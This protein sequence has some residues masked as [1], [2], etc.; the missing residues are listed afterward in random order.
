MNL[1][2][3]LILF[4]ILI[5]IYQ[6]F[7]QIFSILF[8]LTGLNMDRSK[9][10]VISMLT[11]TGFTTAESESV[12]ST[13]RRRRL[14][15]DLMLFSYIFNISI[16]STFVSIFTSSSSASLS[17]LQIGI[18]Y[19]IVNLIVMYWLNKSAT[20]KN[21]LDITINKITSKR[22]KKNIITVFDTYGDKVIAEI[23]L[24]NI[25]ITLANLSIR[26]FGQTHKMQIL[27]I[28]RDDIVISNVS[29]NDIIQSGD[30][31]T[32]FGNLRDIKYIFQDNLKEPI[33]F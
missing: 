6:I 5:L 8:S 25:P 15:Q 32:I 22:L 28:K 23:N 16:V 13:K 14:A 26:D 1:A 4:N 12:V 9:F 11:G 21:F 31:I 2:T 10:Q 27:V 29:V 20:F 18:L 3:S 30:I 33:I 7:V 24:K 17:Q 19:T